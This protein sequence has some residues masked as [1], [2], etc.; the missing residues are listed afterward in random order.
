[1]VEGLS[2]LFFPWFP[3]I[4]IH[5]HEHEVVPSHH[6]FLLPLKTHRKTPPIPALNFTKQNPLNSLSF[7]LNLIS[8]SEL[9]RGPW[10]VFNMSPPPIGCLSAGV[11]P[12]PD[13]RASSLFIRYKLEIGCHSLDT[14]NLIESWVFVDCQWQLIRENWNALCDN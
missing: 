5:H 13:A 12:S 8:S 9:F 10:C 2:I 6:H 1:M 3:F 11:V 7:I 4:N 14:R